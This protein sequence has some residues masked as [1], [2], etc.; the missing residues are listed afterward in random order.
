MAWRTGLLLAVSSI[1]TFPSGLWAQQPPGAGATPPPT[2]PALPKKPT[3]GG[4]N[5]PLHK[6]GLTEFFT[7]KTPYEFWLT[8]LIVAF[9]L[10]LVILI[11]ISISRIKERKPEDISRPII[12]VSVVTAA[13]ILVTAGFSNE[14]IAPAFGLLGTIAGYIFG[15]LSR[16]DD[17]RP[18]S[19][20]DNTHGMSPP[21]QP[22]S[23]A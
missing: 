19:P 14:Q 16:A 8:C 5:L 1:L 4:G 23:G 13:L 6:T 10:S 22:P 15:R 21:A 7:A 3:E 12:V 20:G 2:P 9:G 17:G 18:P 11:W